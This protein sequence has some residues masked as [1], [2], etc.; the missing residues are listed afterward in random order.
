[1]ELVIALVN[2]TDLESVAQAAKR[3]RV[4]TGYLYRLIRL[5]KLD[6]Y[7]IG[8]RLMLLR[9]DVDGFISHRRAS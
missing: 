8:G 3:A 7:E 1:V 9:R 6:S 4:S 5:G 2:T